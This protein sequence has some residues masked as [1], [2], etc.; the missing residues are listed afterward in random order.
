MVSAERLSMVTWLCLLV[1]VGSEISWTQLLRRRSSRR[2]STTKGK[3]C[4][5]RCASCLEILRRWSRRS[6]ICGWSIFVGDIKGGD[7]YCLVVGCHLFLSHIIGAHW[8]SFLVALAVAFII[9]RLSVQMSLQPCFF[10]VCVF[11]N[12][13][14]FLPSSVSDLSEI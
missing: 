11:F 4:G 13:M 8:P 10:S 5:W 14:P 3:D 7:Q 6:D 2:T 1:G 9:F 12:S